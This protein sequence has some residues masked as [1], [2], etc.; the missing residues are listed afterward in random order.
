[1]KKTITLDIEDWYNILDWAS[2]HKNGENPWLWYDEPDPERLEEYEEWE[3]QYNYT[4]LSI[5]KLKAKVVGK[6]GTK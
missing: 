1:M 6:N 2:Q 5:N 4:E 3:Q